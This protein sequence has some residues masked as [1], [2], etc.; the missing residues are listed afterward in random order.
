MK[1]WFGRLPV[2][3][4]LAW[5]LIVFLG[6]IYLVGSGVGFMMGDPGTPEGHALKEKWAPLAFFLG[7]PA[8]WVLIGLS[9]G[10]LIGCFRKPTD[11]PA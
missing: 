10:M 5:S 7:C 4:R 11:P 2:A 3:A 8:G 1:K 9:L 6:G